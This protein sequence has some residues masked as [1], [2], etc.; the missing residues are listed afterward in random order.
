MTDPGW[1]IIPEPK[2]KN[3]LEAAK[4]P[5]QGDSRPAHVKNFLDCVQSRAQPDENLE[6]GHLVSTVAH[7]G[8][9]SRLDPAAHSNGIPRRNGVV[10]DEQADQLVG[11][12]LPRSVVAAL[13]PAIATASR[14]DPA[15]IAGLALCAGL[16]LR[17]RL[18]ELRTTTAR[19]SI[20]GPAMHGFPPE[21][22]ASCREC[23]PDRCNSATSAASA[24]PR[25]VRRS[26]LL[27]RTCGARRPASAPEGGGSV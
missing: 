2:K 10:G 19:V 7:L 16:A 11:V 15:A 3:S 4:S 9:V 17:D 1:E 18:T 5:G 26:R 24:F 12:C 21:G 8:N 20:L 6:L 14:S 25:L 23:R 27:F 22:D 13:L